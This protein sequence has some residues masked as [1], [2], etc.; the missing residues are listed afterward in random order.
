MQ[1]MPIVPKAPGGAFSAI[2]LTILE[3]AVADAWEILSS[4]KHSPSWVVSREEVARAVLAV[5]AEGERDKATLT[6]RTIE[7]LTADNDA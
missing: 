5:A 2:E 7:R 4:Q 6:R 1:I 3:G